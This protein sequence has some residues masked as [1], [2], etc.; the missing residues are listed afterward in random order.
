MP[1]LALLLISDD[2]GFSWGLRRRAGAGCTGEG[3][4]AMA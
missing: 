4:A 1:T 3:S 2:M